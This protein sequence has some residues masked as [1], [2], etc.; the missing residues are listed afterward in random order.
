[1]I[2]PALQSLELEEAGRLV[3]GETRF[4]GLIFWIAAL[5][6]LA[7]LAAAGVSSLRIAASGEAGTLRRHGLIV[8]SFLLMAGAI[9]LTAT[10]AMDPRLVRD[11]QE[12]VGHIAVIVDRSDSLARDADR[13]RAGAAQL[14]D[15]LEAVTRDAGASVG[16]WRASLT[17]FAE[18][19]DV[20]SQDATPAQ[21]AA[22]LRRPAARSF[23]RSDDGSR[24][25]PALAAARRLIQEGGGAGVILLMSDGI[26]PDAQLQEEVRALQRQGIPVYVFAEG[27]RF[28][29]RG[30]VAGDLP[31]S[32]DAGI[33]V[34]LRLVVRAGPEEPAEVWVSSDGGDAR[35]RAAQARPGSRATP[36]RIETTFAGRGLRYLET[37]VEQSDAAA[38][39]RRF[40]TV[41]KSPP[42]ILVYGA[43]DWIDRLPPERLNVIRAPASDPVPYPAEYDVI[44]IDGVTP[45]DFPDAYPETLAKAVSGAGR[46]LF[47]VNGSGSGDPS[48][49]TTTGLWEATAIGPLLPVSTEMR[50][51]VVDPPPRDIAIIID[52]SGSMA[53]GPLETAKAAAQDVIETMRPIDRV[54]LIPFG[55]SK[56]LVAGVETTDEGKRRVIAALN[57]LGAGGGSN[58]APALEAVRGA[59]ANSCAVFFFT[60]GA[61]EGTDG[62]RPGCETVTFEIGYG[63]RVL[64]TSLQ[65]LGQVIPLAEGAALTRSEVDFLEPEIREERWRAGRFTPIAVGE[66][67]LITPA[68]PVDGVVVSYPRP[69][70]ERLLVHPDAPPDPLLALRGDPAQL[71]SGTVA[72]FLSDIPEAWSGSSAGRTALTELLRLLSGWS[73]LDRYQIDVA[74]AGEYLELA[75]LIVQTSDASLPDSLEAALTVAGRGAVPLTL[76]PDAEAPGRFSGVVRLGGEASGTAEPGALYLREAGPNALATPQRI[77][78]RLPPATRRTDAAAEEALAFGVDESALNRLALATGGGDLLAARSRLLS[79]RQ[80]PASSRRLYEWMLAAAT[81][82]F[83]MALWC[84]GG[85]R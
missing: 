36:I 30:V 57:G 26:W 73:A 62:R 82:C 60:D 81:I 70:A 31:A 25:V 10:A 15:V 33:P 21:I 69:E 34:T 18:R 41:V 53:N 37:D 54:S 75:I 38:Q 20:L 72:A 7:A 43:A 8:G 2:C 48:A 3:C 56:P 6:L 35:Q 80:R 78:L 4:E 19:T 24:V 28:P 58:A 52:T 14:A 29:G 85:R 12:G 9:L 67:S 55:V 77:P 23:D 65:S 71:S 39:T 47:L 83:T 45:S 1:M 63:G 79:D 44:V 68:L 11:P 22:A 84:A 40:F 16:R 27:S 51:L 42:R 5:A 74:D 59:S 32:T 50:T 66:P 64:N 61:I 49:E 13:S 46:G 17:T 76:R